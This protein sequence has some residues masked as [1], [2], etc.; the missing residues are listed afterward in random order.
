MVSSVVNNDMQ[1]G[2]NGYKVG[3]S[4]A[5]NFKYVSYSGIG[6]IQSSLMKSGVGFFLNV[7]NSCNLIVHM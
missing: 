2:E 4:M 1:S 7:Y 6:K 5:H 3:H